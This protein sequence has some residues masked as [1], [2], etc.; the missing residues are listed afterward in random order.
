MLIVPSIRRN[1]LA[2]ATS[3]AALIYLFRRLRSL[4]KKRPSQFNQKFLRQLFRLVQILIPRLK[5]DSFALLVT[6]LGTLIS[7]TFLSIYFARLDGAIV[8]SL[9]QR[10]PKDFLRTISIFILVAIPASFVNSFIRFA[11]SKLALAF[12]SKLIEH[13]YRAYFRVSFSFI[14]T[15]R[16][17]CWFAFSH[18]KNQ[19]F[20]RVSNLD[21]R[22]LT[23]DQNLTDDIETFTSTLTHLLSHLTKPFFDVALIS[24]TLISMA[25]KRRHSRGLTGKIKFSISNWIRCFSVDRRVEVPILSFIVVLVT[26]WS[27]RKLSPRFGQL[28]SE[29]ARRRGLLRFAHTRIIA[30]AEEIAF[31]DGH[32]VTWFFFSIDWL[33]SYT[34]SNIPFSRSNNPGSGS[35]TINYAHKLIWSSE[36]SFGLLWQNNFSWNIFGIQVEFFLFCNYLFHA[37]ESRSVQLQLE[38]FLSL[39]HFL[40]MMGQ[41]KL[42]VETRMLTN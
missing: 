34:R 14:S 31:F 35:S 30:N 4:R 24:G 16:H 32:H 22:L 10:N 8:K 3:L 37:N 42:T 36:K 17:C 1:H 18:W 13:A 21:N 15:Y 33:F 28:V 9:V 23:P 27:L 2:L 39:F 7:R 41:S 25:R 12:R 5:S 11:E 26:F 6:H 40:L 20:Y 38:C 19:T 29:E